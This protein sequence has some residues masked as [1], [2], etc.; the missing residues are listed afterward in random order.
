MKL[1]DI[2]FE[3]VID[4]DEAGRKRMTKDEFIRRSEQIHQNEDGSPK[5]TYGNVDYI[6]S[7]TPVLI[8]CPIHGDF[9]QTPNNHL[10]GK[11]CN[12]CGI[13]KKSSNTLDFIRSSESM[14]EHQNEDGTPKYSYGNVV[15]VNNATPV[16]ITCPIHGDFPQKPNTHLS[17]HGC[18]SCSHDDMR[19]NRDYFIQKAQQV[20]QNPDGTPKYTYDNVDYVHSKTNVNITCPIHS[21]THG[22]FSQKPYL[23]LSGTG[24]PWCNESKGEKI[25]ERILFE[26]NIKS[27]PFKK[28]DDCVSYKSKM[29]LNVRCTKLEFDFYLPENNTLVEF[30]GGYHFD[31][32]RKKKKNNKHYEYQILNDK[33]KNEYAKSKGIKLIRISYHD[34]KNIEEELMKGLDST[35]QL[36]L[37]T[38]YP[39]DKGW[40]DTTI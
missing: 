36:Y 17:G 39:T 19:S 16:L 6:K 32:V 21:P 5:Y 12:L 11:G 18:K 3:S 25:I 30:D 20:H 37:S 10:S 15:Y 2:I 40:R 38:N 1:I 33:E 14:P 9:P 22:D 8:T 27:I 7:S 34:M 13:N 29:G 35:E 4:L 26:K 24:C 31:N 28:Y 23:H